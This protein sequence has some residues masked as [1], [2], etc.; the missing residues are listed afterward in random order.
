[1]EMPM[2][3][4][5]DEDNEFEAAILALKTRRDLDAIKPKFRTEVLIE[6]GSVLAE[7][8]GI[9]PSYSSNPETAATPDEAV[10]FINGLNEHGAGHSIAWPGITWMPRKAP[11]DT[12]VGSRRARGWCRRRSHPAVSR[13]AAGS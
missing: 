10:E 13:R 2:A 9:E 8:R 12:S 3:E 4:P 1:M 5:T 11:A 7:R 6:I